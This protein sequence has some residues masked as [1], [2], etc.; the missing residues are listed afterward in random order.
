M[1]GSVMMSQ[2]MGHMW[3]LGNSA[4]PTGCCACKSPTSASSHSSNTFSTL[5]RFGLGAACNGDASLLA[6]PN[7]RRFFTNSVAAA[8]AL[9]TIA[10]TACVAG[11]TGEDDSGTSA[12][13]LA[14]APWSAWVP[15]SGLSR[16]T[17]HWQRIFSTPGHASRG[18]AC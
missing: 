7:D 15:C 12:A 18:F 5:G 10:V 16:K 6:P 17:D 13:L 1:T 9:L 3:W 2:E 4:G 8:A 11:N 14:L